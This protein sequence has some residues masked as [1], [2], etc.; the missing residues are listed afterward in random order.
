MGFLSKLVK[1]IPGVNVALDAI[2]TVGSLINS[3][4]TNQ[5]NLQAVRETNAAN[6]ELAKYNWQQQKEMWNA[7]NA[8]NTP[9]AQMARYRDAGLNPNLIYGQGSAG[10][11]PSIPSPATPTMQAAHLDRLPFDNF[12]KL[13]DSL[14][15]AYNFTLQREKLQK[16]N[17]LLDSQAAA[18]R[19]NSLKSLAEINGITWHGKLLN[20]EFNQKNTLFPYQVSAA[21]QALQS[22]TQDIIAKTNKNSLFEL[23]KTAL[24]IQI[25]LARSGI[26]KNQAQ[27]SLFSQEILES[28]A[29]ITKLAAE[30]DNTVILGQKLGIERDFA[31]A[32]F[33]NRVEMVAQEL[34]NARLKG[35]GIDLSNIFQQNYNN[36]RNKYGYANDNIVTG[37]LGTL[38]YNAGQ[39]GKALSN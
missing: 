25:K 22:T 10:N 11:S 3:N 17:D 28:A 32:T 19:A 23:E 38:F 29:R 20:Q 8:Y 12:H 24:D 34:V 2:G 16:E 27:A 9:S 6:A 13:S 36:Y 7:Q 15:Q 26:A 37:T 39:F 35:R 33:V 31:S 30:T 21:R 18:Q 5:A 14:Q 4:N 1:W